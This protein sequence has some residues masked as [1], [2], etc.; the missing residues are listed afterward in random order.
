MRLPA[1]KGMIDRRILVNF[2]VDPVVVSRLL[3]SPFRPKL[4]SGWAIAG[5]CLIRLK[6][7]RPSGLSLLP[8]A[9]S[10]NAAHRFAVEWEVNGDLREGVFIPRRDSNSHLN[11]IL[12]GRLVPG[13]HHHARFEV[14]ESEDRLSVGYVSDDGQTRVQVAGRVAD[15][16]PVDS[17]FSSVDEASRFFERGSLGYS[18]TENPSRFDGLELRCK[19]WAVQP[20]ATERVESSY[21][22]DR[23]KFP[24]GSAAFDCALLMRGVEHE[25]HTKDDLF[26]TE[27]TKV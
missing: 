27:P 9:G 25:W 13:R 20:L 2:R 17:I 6:D 3:P 11:T 8:G 26:A 18:S 16:L 23:A 10:E 1:I 24:A 22:D 12:G 7:I 14:D 5:I 4:V 15:S 21:F 19:S